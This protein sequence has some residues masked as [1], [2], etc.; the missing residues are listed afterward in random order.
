MKWYLVARWQ[1][2][3]FNQLNG[4][5]NE[6]NHRTHWNWLAATLAAILA[7]HE[8]V[9]DCWLAAGTIQIIKRRPA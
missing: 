2:G 4:R 8:V 1:Q 3:Q 5:H 7:K 9:F 6:E